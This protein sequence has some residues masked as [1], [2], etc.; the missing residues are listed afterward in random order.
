MVALPVMPAANVSSSSAKTKPDAPRPPRRWRYARR[1]RTA[2]RVVVRPLE[3]R[4]LA[5]D[6]RASVALRAEHPSWLLG[7]VSADDVAG[8]V[9]L[10]GAQS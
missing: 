4:D 3:E 10:G 2:G 9:R 6:A 8:E 7:C 1:S 5:G